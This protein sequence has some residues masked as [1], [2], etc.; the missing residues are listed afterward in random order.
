MKYLLCGSAY[1]MVLL[2]AFTDARAQSSGDP[3]SVRPTPVGVNGDPRVRRESAARMQE[4]EDALNSFDTLVRDRDAMRRYL[5][6]R[7]NGDLHKLL[8]SNAELAQFTDASVANPSL[9]EIASAAGRIAKCARSLRSS[10][11]YEV[12][13]KRK[14]DPS[15]AAEI[16]A[17]AADLQQGATEI[18]FLVED[19]AGNILPEFLDGNVAAAGSQSVALAKLHRLEAL[20]RKIEKLTSQR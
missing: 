17:L 10:V 11:T 7:I 3:E 14:A 4:E 6:Q 13:E 8:K 19:L 9:K 20:A 2:I 16:E 18:A 12:R 1:L 15:D 5:R